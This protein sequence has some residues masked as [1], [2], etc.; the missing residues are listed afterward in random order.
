M[1]PS[2]PTFLPFLS[3]FT[4]FLSTSRPTTFYPCLLVSLLFSPASF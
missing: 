4:V 1:S 2:S 3:P